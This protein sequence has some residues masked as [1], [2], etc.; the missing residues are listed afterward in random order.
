MQRPA[1]RDGANVKPMEDGG[2]GDFHYGTDW[3]IMGWPPVKVDRMLRAGGTVRLGEVVLTACNTPGHRRGSTTWLTTLV[4]GGKA[5]KVVL[6]D[7][8]FFNP[9][10]RVAKIRPLP[11]SPKITHVGFYGAAF[12]PFVGRRG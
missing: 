3:K 9:G 6:P 10:Y 5:Y 12:R 11:A 8:G 2:K 4:D 1:R 7:G